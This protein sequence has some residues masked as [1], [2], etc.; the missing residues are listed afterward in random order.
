[1]LS[2]T[3]SYNYRSCAYACVAVS[4]LYYRNRNVDKTSISMSSCRST[5]S[6]RHLNMRTTI[7][8]PGYV[9]SLTRDL[10]ARVSLLHTTLGSL[11]SSPVRYDSK[12]LKLAPEFSHTAPPAPAEPALR[13]RDEGNAETETEEVKCH[14]TGRTL[15][16]CSGHISG[17]MDVFTIAFECGCS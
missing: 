11:L 17:Q 1:M 15:P 7:M 14:A 4:V 13:P 6:V 10:L 5:G 12:S 3:V 16:P 2:I 8:S 9:A